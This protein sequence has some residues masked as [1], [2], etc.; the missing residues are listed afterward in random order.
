MVFESISGLQ[1]NMMKNNSYPVNYVSNLKES[2]DMLSYN[3]GSLHTTYV[4][5][6]LSAKF[7]LVEIWNGVT[8]RMEK[9]LAT[10]QSRCLSLGGTL[11]VINSVLDSIPIYIMSLFH[12]PSSAIKHR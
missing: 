1:I 6:P 2:A 12:M 3:M 4:G 5:L 8:E 11:T 9:R 10:W 7:I